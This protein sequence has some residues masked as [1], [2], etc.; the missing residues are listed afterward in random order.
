MQVS[1]TT[2]NSRSIKNNVHK[3]VN[4]KLNHSY[5]I[6][7]RVI[8]HLDK[9]KSRCLQSLIELSVTQWRRYAKILSL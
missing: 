3:R 7:N 8:S 6:Y 5:I 9:H 2:R 4:I 1:V